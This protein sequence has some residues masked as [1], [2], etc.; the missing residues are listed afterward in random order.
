MP[1]PN[2]FFAVQTRIQTLLLASSYYSGLT[3]QILTE[4]V[5]DLDFQVNKA[6]LPLGFGAIITTATGKSFNAEFNALQSMEDFNVSIVWNPKLDPM[7]NT[8]DALTAAIL[9]IHGQTV[10]TTPP[11]VK[12]P[13]DCFVV[14]G[15]QPRIDGPPDC[16]VHELHVT[17]GLR[18]L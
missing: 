6:I 5:G 10:Q 18:L 16:N 4:E 2:P 13:F 11:P 3:G 1:T 17:G 7:H 9:A 8:L 15:H 12:R 14:T